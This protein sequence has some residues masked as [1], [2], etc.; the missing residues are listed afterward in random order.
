M[1][2]FNAGK[3][4][5]I[6]FEKFAPLK[7]VHILRDDLIHPIVCGNKW[8]KLKYVIEYLKAGNFET[9][10]TFG[11]AYS[12]HVVATAFA[13]EQFGYKT[14]AFIRGDENRDLN[15]YEQ[16]CI[17]HKMTLHHV[18]RIVYK[19]KPR[20]FNQYF[21]NDPKAFFLDEGGNHELALKGCAEIIGELETIYDYIILP[22]GTGTT[23]EGML[24]GVINQ[25]LKTRILGISSLK[26]NFELDERMQEY[27]GDNWRIF[28]EF[29][30]G[31]YGQSDDKL[32]Q[33]I[34]NFRSET[35]VPLEN[36]YTGKMM[37]G[38]IE[39]IQQNY[40]KPDDKILLIHTGGLLNTLL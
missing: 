32:E 29:H 27:N 26:N 11:G 19:D 36:V 4:E 12:N 25:N 16:L 13:G 8:R 23:M 5:S 30:R 6:E 34:M 39:L 20:L 38:F 14:H 35:N 40:F 15:H 17:N 28:H 37:M 9:I 24:Q 18:S 1:A 33:F 7:H 22:L 21:Q 31:K 3:V 2:V 10:V